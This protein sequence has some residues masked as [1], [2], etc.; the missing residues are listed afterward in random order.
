MTEAS[1]ES[2]MSKRCKDCGR[3]SS[4]ELYHVRSGDC[5]VCK[6]KVCKQYLEEH[7]ELCATCYSAGEKGYLRHKG[8][9]SI[10]AALV[11][12]EAEKARYV[13]L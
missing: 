1:V 3:V 5:I 11:V 9:R 7:F 8:N 6:R 4:D 10:R 2:K 12:S 13:L